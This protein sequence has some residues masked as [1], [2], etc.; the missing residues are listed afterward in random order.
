MSPRPS[1]K[2]IASNVNSKA[3]FKA[4]FKTALKTA[5]KAAP[6]RL[7]RQIHD[8]IQPDRVQ[9]KD[10]ANHAITD[11]RAVQAILEDTEK[12]HEGTIECS[13]IQPPRPTTSGSALAARQAETTLIIAQGQ[14]R[15]Q[16]VAKSTSAIFRLPQTWL[17]QQF[18][19]HYPLHFRVKS[20]HNPS[21]Y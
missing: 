9:L 17:Q 16:T 19:E 4:T 1:N 21:G 11:A 20:P 10:P 14:A 7:A 12:E 5:S 6:G 2:Q 18:N 15:A 13:Q 3:G 8:H